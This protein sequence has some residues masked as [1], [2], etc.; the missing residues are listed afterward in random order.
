VREIGFPGAFL[1][2]HKKDGTK[3]TIQE[4]KELENKK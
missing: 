1:L 4:A 2:V 3:I